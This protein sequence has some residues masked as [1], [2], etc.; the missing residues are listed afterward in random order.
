M[1]S[2]KP[3]WFRE[4]P[5][6]WPKDL[7]P[8]AYAIACVEVV[9]EKSEK[10]GKIY[11]QIIEGWGDPEVQKFFDAVNSEIPDSAKEDV[12]HALLHPESILLPDPN[13]PFKQLEDL[14]AEIKRDKITLA[15]GIAKKFDN[16]EKQRQESFL[17]FINLITDFIT[18]GFNRESNIAKGQLSVQPDNNRLLL[19]VI[20]RTSAEYQNIQLE[21]IRNAYKLRKHKGRVID[22]HKELEEKP[23]SLWHRQMVAQAKKY[24]MKLKNDRVIMAAAY[25]WYQ[26][27]VVHPSVSKYCDDPQNSIIDTKNMERQ[28]KPCDEA[29]EYVG[30][31]PA[32]E[33]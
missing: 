4:T 5:H 16:L 9:A 33:K 25:H 28:I 6:R 15:D 23:T 27:R 7:L 13:D 1:R 2:K 10:A 20:M 32:Q 26:A 3:S 8:L 19:A 29:L 24:N 17:N 12:K 18:L 31:L 14:F 30:R 22:F 11:E 21:Q